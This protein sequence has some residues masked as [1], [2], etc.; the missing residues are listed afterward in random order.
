MRA[1]NLVPSDSAR[2][3][4]SAFGAYALL[5][6]L[7]VLLAGVVAYVLTNN[8]L[9]ERRAELDSL[10][11]QVRAAQAQAAA[12]RPYREFAAL[13][14]ARVKTVRE[15]GA[16]R[17]D[18]SRAFRELA[19]VVPDSVWLDELLGTVTTGVTVEGAGSASTGPLR[20]QLPNPAIEL[21][22]CTTSHE[23]VARLIS[24]LRLMTGVVRVSLAD[25]GKAERIGARG[26][27]ADRRGS[28]GS[29]LDARP[30]ATR[31]GLVVFFEPP[32]TASA[33][34]GGG[35]PSVQPA[36]SSGAAEATPA[37]SGHASGSDMR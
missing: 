10:R 30:G 36:S 20:S 26:G 17:F 32:P 28:S 2:D 21:V 29:C 12:T 5:A 15:L 4:G 22:G 8:A 3:V 34:A 19:R 23:G 6:V 11:T 35:A 33:P 1:V 27:A 18:W 7:G 9:V 25:S 37:A 16:A 31:F 13:A 14:Q 24:R